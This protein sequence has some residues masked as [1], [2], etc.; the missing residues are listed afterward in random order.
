MMFS[1][2]SFVFLVYAIFAYSLSNLFVFAHGPFHLFDHIRDGAARISEETGELF[3]CMICFPTW[4]GMCASL[5]NHFLLP[6]IPLT[7]T[8]LIV[9]QSIMPWWCMM[10]T[11]GVIT[12]G[13]VWLIH[14]F[15]EMMERINQREE[16][17]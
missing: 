1:N 2:V 15:Q 12:S 6:E 13:L 8:A 9:G 17:E 10:I 16:D 5:A 3:Q 14:T 4:V 11:D 7:P